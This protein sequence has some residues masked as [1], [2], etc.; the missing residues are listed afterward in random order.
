VFH[1]N[2]NPALIKGLANVKEQIEQ[3]RRDRVRQ[4]V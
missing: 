3:A 2:S 1:L 4:A